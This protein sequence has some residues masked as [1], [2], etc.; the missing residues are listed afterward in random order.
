LAGSSCAAAAVASLTF[1]EAV[2]LA[3]AN[4]PRLAARSAAIDAAQAEASRAGALPDPQ[5]MLGID[6]LPVT[7]GDAFDSSVDEMTMRSIGLRQDLPSSARRAAHR[8]LAERRVGE[9]QAA[10][11]TDALDVRRA[12]ADAWIDAWAAMREVHAVERLREQARLA[13]TLARARASG[14]EGRLA[15]ALAAEASGLEL[16]NR[17]EMAR[18]RR[19]AALAMLG[20]WVPAQHAIEVAGDPD[21]ETLPVTREQL[22]ARRDALGPVLG[23][24][25]R[26]ETAAAAMDLA[27]A[28]KRPDWSVSASYGQRGRDRSD[29]L[30]VEVG[31]SLPLFASRRQDLGV[32]AREAEYQ[33]A[34]ALRDDERLAL[35]SRIDAAF[36]HW[37]SLKRQVALHE[38]RLLP[39]ARDRSAA[40]LAAYRAGGELQPW[41]DARA[42]ELDV[43]RAHAEHLGELGHAWAALAFLLPEATP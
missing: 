11:I 5:L 13:A 10:A 1:A 20:R 16:D 25:A 19:D 3:G 26:V 43:H 33:Q 15:D 17:L 42:A 12:A 4:A 32:S 39:L 29:M 37:E 22:L 41:L 18:G 24:T 9:A 6:N 35:A 2:R 34:L 31:V 7:G 21:F 28:E 30:S 23:G 38:D 40:A 14:G 8:S 36:V 27:R